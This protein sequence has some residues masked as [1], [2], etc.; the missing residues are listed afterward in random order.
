MA[1]H[2]TLKSFLRHASN[3]LIAAYLEARGIRL[4][5]DPRTVKRAESEKLFQA[6]SALPADMRMVVEQEFQEITSLGDKAGLKHIR[7]E[8][9]FRRLD[10]DTGLR[11]QRSH[12][13]RALWTFVNHREVFDAAERIAAPH[14]YGRY[15]K[16]GLPLISRPGVNLEEMEQKLEVALR[17]H[18]Q[19]EDGRGESCKVDYI[20]RPPLHRFH[21]YP[22]DYPA[23]PLAWRTPNALEP[24]PHRPAFE[25]VFVYDEEAGTLDVYDE[26]GKESVERLWPLFAKVVLGVEDLP[27]RVAPVYAL[28]CFT[29]PSLTFPRPPDSIVTDL[30]VKA[31]SLA[32]QDRD[33]ATVRIEADV[34][35]DRHALHRAIDRFFSDRPVTG[36]YALSQ[37]RVI[38]AR[39]Q[40]TIDRHDGKKPRTRTFDISPKSCSLK[41]DGIDLEL[42][43]IL[44]ESGI[45]QTGTGH[46]AGTRSSGRA[47]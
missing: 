26:G 36:R 13:D 41:N 17:D 25:V 29:L 21:A 18:F 12:I 19:N 24:L 15:W 1:T 20:G 32:V 40:A 43:R 5:L 22:E 42:R 2:F 39:I 6:V 14:L 8:A 34:S 31:L 4:E 46:D 28:Q 45:D 3:E 44:L 11:Q 7:A 33:P 16:R 47:A 9:G 38:G 23:A 35:Q 37:A 10:L 27:D 30:R